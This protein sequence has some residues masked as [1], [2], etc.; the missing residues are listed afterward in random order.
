MQSPQSTPMPRLPQSLMPGPR[1]FVRPPQYQPGRTSSRPSIPSSLQPNKP[2]N[3]SPPSRP[4]PEPPT[5]ATLLPPSRPPPSP[6]AHSPTQR[7]VSIPSFFPQ[8]SY[9]SQQNSYFSPQSPTSAASYVAILEFDPRRSPPEILSP[10]HSDGSRKVKPIG[11]PVRNLAKSYRFSLPSPVREPYEFLP[12]PITKRSFS[13][14]LIYDGPTSATS[15]TSTI[16]PRTVP[17]PPRERRSSDPTTPRETPHTAPQSDTPTLTPQDLNEITPLEIR[18]GP[19]PPSPSLP[20]RSPLREPQPRSPITSPAST[21][22]PRDRRVSLPSPRGRYTPGLTTVDEQPTPSPSPEKEPRN[23]ARRESSPPNVKIEI[24][25]PII[26]FGGTGF[27]TDSGYQGG[28]EVGLDGT[29]KEVDNPRD[30]KEVMKKMSM[31]KSPLYKLLSRPRPKRVPLPRISTDF[32]V[33]ATTV[34]LETNLESR[35]SLPPSSSIE[36][37]TAQTL[38]SP[39]SIQFLQSACDEDTDFETGPLKLRNP[40]ELSHRSSMASSASSISSA[41]PSLERQSAELS[42]IVDSYLDEI[43][44]GSDRGSISDGLMEFLRRPSMEIDDDDDDESN[45]GDD[46]EDEEGKL[47]V[48]GVNC[49]R[50]FSCVRRALR[51]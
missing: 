10:I 48:P 32:E 12:R 29:R 27:P 42:D 51:D 26:V 45:Y 44:S 6:P 1:P 24:P 40:D 18:H 28:Y 50:S 46:D 34:P 38:D 19:F 36:L 7:R 22:N 14:P 3:S 43:A 17:P 2:V 16:T 39:V 4:L 31:K 30:G 8:S 41:S 5:I 13:A 25:S 35:E 20:P 37:Q 23:N 47:N 9:S 15:P 11:M 21:P 33:V 49:V